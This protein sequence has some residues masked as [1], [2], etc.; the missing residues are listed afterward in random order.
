[1]LVTLLDENLAAAVLGGCTGLPSRQ[2]PPVA[3]REGKVVVD[4]GDG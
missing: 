4:G 3:A 1:V 2:F